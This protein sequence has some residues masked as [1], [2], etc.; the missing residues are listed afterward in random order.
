MAVSAIRWERQRTAAHRFYVVDTCRREAYPW[1]VR[2]AEA[3][4]KSIAKFKSQ[5]DAA[6]FLTAVRNRYVTTDSG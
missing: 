3:E 2:N 5:N 4:P 1:Q 6:L